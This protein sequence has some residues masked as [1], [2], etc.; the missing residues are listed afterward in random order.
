M[1]TLPGQAAFLLF[2]LNTTD[3][4]MGVREVYMKMNPVPWGHVLLSCLLGP[5]HK[6]GTLHIVT[7]SMSCQ[8]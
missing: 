1:V 5:S 8:W 3:M 6:E 7:E 4:A 2:S